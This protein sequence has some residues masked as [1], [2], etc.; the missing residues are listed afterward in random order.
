M[1]GPP[2]HPG[3]ELVLELVRGAAQ[4]QPCPSCQQSLVGCQLSLGEADLDH[5]RAEVTCPACQATFTL[6]VSPSTDG[7]VARLG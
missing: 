3:L 1:S 2:I 4:D 6:D 5:V 7:G